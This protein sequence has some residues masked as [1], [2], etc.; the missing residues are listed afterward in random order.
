MMHTARRATLLVV[1]PAHL[2]ATTASAQSA[3]VGPEKPTVTFS[4]WHC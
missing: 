3:W 4:V 2:L 1:L